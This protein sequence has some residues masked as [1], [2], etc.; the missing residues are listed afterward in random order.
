MLRAHCIRSRL[1]F[2]IVPAL[3]SVLF[4]ACGADI[5]RGPTAYSK[6]EA[7]ARMLNQGQFPRELDDP[8]QT[9]NERS[10]FN[11]AAYDQI[12]DNP[13]LAV[14]DHP[15]STFSID[16]DTASYSNV[17]RFLNEGQLPPKDAVRIADF[18][19]YFHY[20]YPQPRNEHPM[21]VQAEIA[22]CPWNS[23]HRLA[24]I[25][26]QGRRIVT[27]ELPPRNLV[28]L[29]DTSGSM[30][31][32]SRLPLVQ[33]GLALLVEQLTAQDRVAIVTYA[34]QAGLRLESTPGNQ[35][36]TILNVVNGLYASGCTNGGEG[37]IQA[38][39]IAQENFIADGAN[40]VILATDGDFNV[41]VT[42]QGDLLRLIEEKR[43]SGVYLTVLGF[44]MDNL[45]DST[46]EKLADKG[47][48]HYAYIDSLAEAHKVFVE[49]GAALITI[50]KDVKVQVEFNPRQVS[51][52]RLIGY[53]NRLLRPEEFNDDHRGATPM[54]AGHTVTALY[55]ISPAGKE[56]QLP[57]IDPLKYQQ[58][59]KSTS[60]ADTSEAFS[61]KVR[62]KEPKEE[63]S[64][65]L[66]L[67]AR[68]ES[69]NFDDAPA[70]FKFTAAAA[71]F[72]MLLRGSPHKGSANYTQ[73]REWA[74][75][76]SRTT[77]RSADR[78]EF[79]RLVDKAEL[80]AGKR[81]AGRDGN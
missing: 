10:E 25:G 41:G 2:V 30:E 72:G 33:K 39:R 15:L 73:V 43:K 21:S 23:G 12:Y 1:L 6:K 26:L 48:G 28:F 46:L 68:D 31:R 67:V 44:G 16:V 18:I 24:R 59:R 20:D 38:Y 57:G 42:N 75:Q 9:T 32:P 8:N 47:N 79:I 69:K 35:K 65:L 62:Y 60:A 61:V 5:G 11:T 64:Q 56:I 36:A 71:G 52:Y 81:L 14:Q 17:R 7:A 22:G 51:A 27:E 78:E 80:L 49:N 50:A 66:T 76:A 77:R 13:F 3:V 54:G 40:R 19:N 53:E 55:E 58:P 74:R 34:G 70:D 4:P 63:T 45:K 29:I 37:I